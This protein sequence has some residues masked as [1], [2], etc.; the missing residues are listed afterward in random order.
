ML[1]GYAEEARTRLASVMI[2]IDK[3]FI[4]VKTDLLASCLLGH[5]FHSYPYEFVEY[6]NDRQR[7]LSSMSDETCI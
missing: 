3:V 5:D 7:C 4:A 1:S 2:R 6:L